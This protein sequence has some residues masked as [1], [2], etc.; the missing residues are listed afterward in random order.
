MDSGLGFNS[1]SADAWMRVHSPMSHRTSA[2]RCCLSRLTS[3][4]EKPNCKPRPFGRQ[5]QV[6]R[7]SRRRGTSLSINVLSSPLC[8]S[9]RVLLRGWGTDCDRALAPQRVHDLVDLAPPPPLCVSPL[10][11]KPA[12]LFQHRSGEAAP[13]GSAQGARAGHIRQRRGPPCTLCTVP[14]KDSSRVPVL[15]RGVVRSTEFDVLF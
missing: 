1:S 12:D 11:E 10:Q 14:R 15:R 5:W 4:A 3:D 2:L 7:P 8:V 13:T 9:E 6:V